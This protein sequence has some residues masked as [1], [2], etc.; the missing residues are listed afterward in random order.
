MIHLLMRAAIHHQVKEEKAIIPDNYLDI[1]RKYERMK[2]SEKTKIKF[3]W[4]FDIKPH[5]LNSHVF[6]NKYIVMNSK[7]ATRLILS[8]FGKNTPTSMF[9]FAKHKWWDE[10]PL[11]CFYLKQV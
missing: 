11:H 10:L 3:S 8:T 5:I 1:L 4:L 2:C 9:C 7:W 6:F